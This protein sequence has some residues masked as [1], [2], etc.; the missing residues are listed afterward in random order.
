[1]GLVQLLWF[2]LALVMTGL[3][4]SLRLEDFARLRTQLRGFLV[5]LAIQMLLLPLVALAIAIGFDL[6]APLAIGMILLAATPGSISANLFS[7]LF[8]G[9]VA[10]NVALTGI[11]TFLCALTLPLLLSAAIHFFAG[12]GQVI[13]LQL[14]RAVST[15]ALVIVPVIVGMLVAA[16]APTFARRVVGPVKVLSALVII[17]F[18]VAAIVKEWAALSS[19]FA[20]IGMSV[21]LFNAAGLAL[22]AVLGRFSGL[23]PPEKATITFQVSVHNAIQAIYVAIVVLE[24]AEIALPAAIYSISMN[25]FALAAGLWMIRRR[26]SHL[27]DSVRASS[28]PVRC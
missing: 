28:D 1:M 10:F 16:R 22:G 26:R 27:R 11:N 20:S 3:G 14:G 25:I 5:T 15:M 18:S 8:G 17:V 24:Q 12:D 4:L 21:L 7:H 6:P 2:A 23:G 13:P 9:N 19:G